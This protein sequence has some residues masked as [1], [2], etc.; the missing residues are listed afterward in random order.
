MEKKDQLVKQMVAISE[1]K[2]EYT[3]LRYYKLKTQPQSKRHKVAIVAC[4]NK[5]LEVT[6]QLL[7][8]GILYDYASALPAQKS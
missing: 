1:G 5:F 3:V 2:K 7:T 8:H 4:I 6:F